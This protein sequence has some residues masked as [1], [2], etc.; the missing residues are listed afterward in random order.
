MAHLP[1]ARLRCAAARLG[2][3][4]SHPT[5]MPDS[6]R[7]SVTAR[8]D[9]V[10]FALALVVTLM[11]ALSAR[12]LHAQVAVG[13]SLWQLGRT[14]EAAQAYRRALA[15]DR[16]SVRANFRV[17]QT[18]AWNRNIDSALVLLRAARERVPDDPEFLLT[19]AMYLSWDQRWLESIVR[20]DS[21]IAA[22]P[23][24]EM[25]RARIARAR[26]LSWA[27]RLAEAQRGYEDVRRLDPENREARFGL[28][29]VRAWSGDLDGGAR[30]FEALLAET[31]GDLQA[32]VGLGS[33]RLWQ[34]RLRTASQLAE[35]AASRDSANAE[36]RT[37]LENV[38]IQRVTKLETA[39]FWSEDSERNLNRWQTLGWRRLVG[40]GLRLGATAGFLDA[41]D[42]LRRATRGMAE[43]SIAFPI[44]RGTVSAAVGARSITAA[45]APGDP[46]RGTRQVLTGRASAI[47]RLT[48][49]LSVTAAGARWPF[50]EIA[51]V[52]PLAL[53]VTQGDVTVE[54][55]P[56][57]TLSLSGTTGQFDYSD[58]NRR[59][60]WGARASLRV[61]PNLTLGGFATGFAFE[62]PNRA[63]FTNGYFAPATFSSAEVTAAWGREGTRWSAGL[64]GG[65]GIQQVDTA[66]VQ[67]QWHADARL[68]RR[69]GARWQVEG[70]AGKSTSAA[71]SAVGAYAYTTGSL[72]FRRAF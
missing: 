1:Q 38:R 4:L 23:G 42:P 29:Q 5:D 36:V 60:N 59:A 34:G 3:P 53:D 50:D 64:S 7:A 54:W 20:Y 18:L 56:R 47:V 57:P 30:G 11:G 21:V 68:A 65:A 69:I 24:P 37:L 8:R 10:A 35:R 25:L 16:N 46:V 15:E 66:Q 26:V 14:D 13:D 40:D 52:T 58:G 31:P 71:A 17:A 22:N 49:T 63:G 2:H 61:T 6:R 62:R 43:A 48:S 33:I 51:V 32:L 19:E 72:T 55:R 41:T 67:S 12:P 27:G 28:A 39:S 45:Q 70:F 9:G 44:P